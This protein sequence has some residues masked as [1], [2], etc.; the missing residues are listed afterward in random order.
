[1][2]KRNFIKYALALALM[3]R[4][5]FAPD[6]FA[7]NLSVE[8]DTDRTNLAI[9]ERLTLTIKVTA[10][11]SGSLPDP[12]LPGH[13]GFEIVGR[14]Y[15]S[16][17]FSWVN[18][19]VSSSKTV[20]YTLMAREAGSFSI[21]ESRVSYNGVDYKTEALEVSV[22]EG[23]EPDAS[24]EEGEDRTSLDISG[25][26]YGNVM[27]SGTLDKETVYAGEWV[28]Y[29]FSFFRRIRLWETPSY[30]SPDFKDFWVEDIS[31]SSPAK[32]VVVKGEKYV[33]QDIKK[34]LFPTKPGEI[35]I[36]SARI[37]LQTAPFSNP[38]TLSTKPLKLE[39]LPLPEEPPA[40]SG[41]V[42]NF[43]IEAMTDKQTVKEGEPVSV[44][45]KIAGVG[46]IK[47]LPQPLYEESELFRGYEPKDSVEISTLNDLI[48]GAKTFEY[49]FIPVKAGNLQ[50]PEFSFTFFDPAEEQFRTI[51]T[52]RIGLE[53]LEDTGDA[54]SFLDTEQSK[55]GDQFRVRKNL[56]PIRTKSD[57]ANWRV[58][59]YIRGIYPWII[60]LPP[61][62]LLLAAAARKRPR[63]RAKGERG[64]AAIDEDLKKAELL[65]DSGKD[66]EFFSITVMVLKKYIMDRLKIPAKVMTKDEFIGALENTDCSREMIETT[67]DLLDKADIGRYSPTRHSKTE[68]EEFLEEVKGIMRSLEKNRF[69]GI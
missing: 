34:A 3:S 4:L 16:S 67:A 49:L 13:T 45:V 43:A 39:V 22:E 69:K 24:G 37:T 52:E 33:R 28:V 14:P 31:R 57:L 10:D 50:L 2:K 65:I 61:L 25:D 48:S 26:S 38:L 44:K 15:Q 9:G 5:L 47:A 19:K 59:S 53:V 66:K 18:G 36:E 60:A 46:N 8:A 7:F 1:V 29:T 27:V 51:N 62:F 17:S 6:A 41:A 11:I 64:Q 56:H 54:A 68:M 58:K 55:E 21:G 20:S 35:T 63:R 42:G 23:A 12:E 40:F 30:V 32:E